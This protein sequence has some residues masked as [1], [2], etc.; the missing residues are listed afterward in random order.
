MIKE[1]KHIDK[2]RPFPAYS[3]RAAWA[4]LPE[5]FKQ[6][7]L[8]EAQK[9]KD[10][11]WP[12]LLVCNYL[13]FSRNG[14]RSIYEGIYF[15]RRQTLFN[16]LLAECISGTGE[17][18]HQIINGVWL[19]CEEST[20]V[21]PAH[22]KKPLPCADEDADID[23]FAAE[24][25]S[26][27]SWVYYFLGETIAAVCPAVK[28]RMECEIE[29]RIFLPY[30]K[31]DDFWWMGFVDYWVNNWNPWINSNILISFL[32]FAG[33]FPR[34]LDGIN[35]SIRSITF[36]YDFYPEDG[37]CDEGPLY[38]TVAG[39]SFID[40]IEELSHVTDVSE[41]FQS[42]KLKNMTAFIYKVY[43][44]GR[45]YV[46]Y[47]DGAP[48]GNIPV[49]LLLRTGIKNADAT[50]VNFSR[51]LKENNNAED[52]IAERRTLLFRL[53]SDAFNSKHSDSEKGVLA[54]PEVNW[55]S[56]IQVVTARDNGSSEKGFFFSAKGGNNSESHNHNDVG[57][58]IL[59]YDG[60]PVIIDAGV[61]TYTK[62]TF[63]EKRYTIWTMQS[64][65]H[66][67]PTINGAD[68][69]FGKEYCA[70]DVSFSNEGDEV[71][72][73]FNIK[74]TY[75]ADAGINSYKREFVFRRGE[76]LFITDNYSLKDNTAPLVLNLLCYD[77]PKEHTSGLL[78]GDK[79]LLEYTCADLEWT[80]QAIPLTDPKICTDWNNR[81]NLYRLQLTLKNTGTSGVVKLN[82][83]A[84]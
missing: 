23:L 56:D 15:G 8:C 45:Y 53:L 5:N 38:F 49:D 7:V 84:L 22:L 10:M 36:F 40:F 17:Y 32:V 48:Q 82:F 4:S 42:Q 37:G 55:L 6:T 65:Y 75:P 30:L 12:S 2:F 29:K 61:E 74:K 19:I 50:L 58:F 1:L 47:A 80:T 34:Y 72:F 35:K 73:S 25:A 44:S 33:T 31:R 76:G 41:L 28:H 26:L 11:V 78:L 39:A 83:T 81:E 67:V 20:W 71:R 68:Q 63:N 27:I 57:N 66:N 18:I 77:K 46:N 13:D 60:S 59:Y 43:I 64:C 79:V 24:T 3:D 16:L 52:I 62:F 14:N 54:L 69:L 9:S 70:E 21:V 51:W